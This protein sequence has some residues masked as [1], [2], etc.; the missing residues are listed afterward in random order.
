[1]NHPRSQHVHT[2][3]IDTTEFVRGQEQKLLEQLK[4]QVCDESVTLDL[5]NVARIDAAGLAALITLYCDACKAG[6]RFRIANPSHH[7]AELLALVHLDRL[8]VAEDTEEISTP[9]LQ[10][11]ESA[12]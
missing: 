12:A 2:V 10:F 5:R 9:V 11:Q 6:Y 8:L 1:M 3:V 4:P 7:V